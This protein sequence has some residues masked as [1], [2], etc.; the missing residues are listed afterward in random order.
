MG[1]IDSIKK[2]PLFVYLILIVIFVFWFGDQIPVEYKEIL[3]ALS[4]TIKD[5]LVFVLP[6]IIFSCLFS[7]ML[8]FK[9]KALLFVIGL[10]IFICASNYIASL[11]GFGIGSF[12]SNFLDD[13]SRASI[14]ATTT[15]KPAW[16][17][18]LQGWID[19]KYALLAGLIG[20]L[21]AARFPNKLIS[22]LSDK[23]NYYV[24]FFL[25]KIFLPFLP[26]FATGFVIK[27]QHEGL[28]DQVFKTYMPIFLIIISTFIIY[29]FVMFLIAAKFNIKDT[30]I[31][32]RRAFPSGI[33]GFSSLSS[34][35]ALP[36]NLDAAE[37]SAENSCAARA[38]IPATV[39]SHL[40]GDSTAVPI[41]AVAVL[42]TFDLPLPDI[43][44]FMQFAFILMMVKFSIVAIPAGGIVV[45]LA[46]LATYLGF[47][48][49][50]VGLLMAVYLLFEPVG[51]FANVMGNNAAAIILS[52][53]TGKAGE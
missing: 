31:F 10:L 21:I 28:L 36:L 52:R 40:I 12:A 29:L 38:I 22:D 45:I 5:L 30:F 13:M 20:G 47:S 42:M 27:M 32:I 33:L 34:M 19:N 4:E 49:E 26:L 46:P 37:K 23:L 24:H 16:D 1:I 50:M 8:A 44:T 9:N 14:S 2:V 3:F 35:A 6:V 18:S 53:F 11:I 15:L 41:M 51:T 25:K 17:L 7:S 48:G 39:N 43:L